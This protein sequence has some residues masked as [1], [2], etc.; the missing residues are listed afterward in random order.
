MH[1]VLEILFFHHY[2][3]IYCKN[4]VKLLHVGYLE[5]LITLHCKLF[6][7]KHNFTCRASKSSV[8]KEASFSRAAF[9]II[10]FS[11]L[12]QSRAQT[13][14]PMRLRILKIINKTSTFHT[15]LLFLAL[16]DIKK[17]ERMFHKLMHTV[18]IVFFVSLGSV[19]V[20]FDN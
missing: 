9:A 15:C 3:F 13:R 2:F 18:P 7:F 12:V 20:H 19:P 16:F 14:R 17:K 6:C 4:C 5:E 8:H 11:S 10:C 1:A